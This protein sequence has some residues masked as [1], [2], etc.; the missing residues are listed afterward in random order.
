MGEAAEMAREMERVCRAL[1]EMGIHL[2]GTDQAASAL[3]LRDQVTH[4]PLRTLVDQARD[5]AERVIRH[6]RKQE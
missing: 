6:L 2:A 3:Q 1:A 4:S 5:S